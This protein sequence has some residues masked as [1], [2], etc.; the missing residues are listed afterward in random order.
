[1]PGAL[2]WPRGGAAFACSRAASRSR[3]ASTLHGLDGAGQSRRRT[4]PK[5]A[6]SV[7][8]DGKPVAVSP[9]GLFAFGFDYDQTKPADCR[10]RFADGTTET[11]P[12]TP[13][14]RIYEIQRVNGLPQKFVTPPADVLARIKREAAQIAHARSARYAGNLVSPTVSTGRA[15]ASSAACSATSASTMA[16]RWRRISASISRR[17]TGTPIHAPADAHRGAGRTD[18]FLDGG[19]TVLDHGHGVFDLLSAPERIAGERPAM[20]SSAGR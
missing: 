10:A 19:F 9:Q 6:R 17:P 18:F 2:F 4:R 13:T 11:Q 5:R 8:V 14:V 3:R 15:R 7:T 20:S 16:R 1:M 12:V